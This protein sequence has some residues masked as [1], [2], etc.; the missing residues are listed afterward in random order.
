MS[1]TMFMAPP[2][3]MV[4]PSRKRL[5]FRR[6]RVLSPLHAV[7]PGTLRC[8]FVRARECYNKCQSE[9]NR[10]IYNDDL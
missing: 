8:R 7:G 9:G 2:P 10:F 3:L 6:T 4:V 1:K 5:Y